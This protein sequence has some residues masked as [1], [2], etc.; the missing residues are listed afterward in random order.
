MTIIGSQKMNK[1][2]IIAIMS[3]RFNYADEDP[4][5]FPTIQDKMEHVLKGMEEYNLLKYQQT[6]CK[7]CGVETKLGTGSARCRECWD[8]KNGV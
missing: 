3:I 4:Y 6:F 5:G 7:D 1:K 8:D 2:D